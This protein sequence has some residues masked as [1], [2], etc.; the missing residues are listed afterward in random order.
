MA[1]EY[2]GDDTIDA[3]LTT[4]W[5]IKIDPDGNI[6]AERNQT[7]VTGTVNADGSITW[8]ADVQ[9]LGILR[10]ARIRQLQAKADQAKRSRAAKP[11]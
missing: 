2:P 7:I 11:A 6:V 8:G 1:R 4:G 9:Q 10:E 5:N 3:L